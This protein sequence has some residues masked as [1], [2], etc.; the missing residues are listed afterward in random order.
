M[1]CYEVP[2]QEE[3][4]TPLLLSHYPWDTGYRP[5]VSVTLWCK[6]E[7]LV[8]FFRVQEEEILARYTKPNS[9]V[10][11]DSCV[12]FFVNPYP[13]LHKSYVNFEVNPLGTLLLQFGPSR[14]ERRFLDHT[15]LQFFQEGLLSKEQGLW[16]LRFQIPLSWFAT[17]YEMEH[18]P[19][20]MRG[21][22]YK[23][24]DDLQKP[25]YGAWS[26]ICLPQPD[27]H[28]PDFFGTLLLPAV[29]DSRSTSSRL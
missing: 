16:T 12:E 1:E 20:Q 8:L 7:Q 9:P 5:S 13:A 11:K 24:G 4:S 10:Y 19:R 28:C 26:P 18:Y 22:F 25:H 2:T 6:N 29:G 17:L 27:F 15:P 21:N 3:Q 23:C 14:E